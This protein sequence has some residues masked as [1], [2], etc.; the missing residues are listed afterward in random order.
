[1]CKIFTI[2]MW[3]RN[4]NVEVISVH[5]CARKTHTLQTFMLTEVI[6]YSVLMCATGICYYCHMFEHISALC[7]SVP[8]FSAHQRDQTSN[9]CVPALSHLSKA[10]L[11]E[12]HHWELSCVNLHNLLLKKLTNYGVEFHTSI[13][14]VILDVFAYIGTHNCKSTKSSSI[15]CNVYFKSVSWN[16]W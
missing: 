5:T 7:P 13:H 9:V 11:R 4:W 8:V 16:E 2:I 6:K 12:C 10:Q 3:H 14:T 1:M 15:M